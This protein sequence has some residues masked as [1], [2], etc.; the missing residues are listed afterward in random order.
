MSSVIDLKITDIRFFANC[1]LIGLQNIV[2]ITF[3][4]NYF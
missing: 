1:D 4:N 2:Y 3:K